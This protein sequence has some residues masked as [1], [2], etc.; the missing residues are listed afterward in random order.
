MAGD[1]VRGSPGYIPAR[2]R[3]CPSDTFPHLNM[4]EPKASLD[5]LWVRTL[6]NLWWVWAF[7]CQPIRM[8]I[9]KDPKEA[10]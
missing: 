2:L 1:G 9:G 7:R 5:R 4:V 3:L 10:F 6:A 8:G